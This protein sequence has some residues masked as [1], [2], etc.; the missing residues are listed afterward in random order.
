[1]HFAPIKQ[2]IG[3]IIWY[4]PCQCIISWKICQNILYT[5]GAC[6]GYSIH[7]FTS[8][9]ARLT[10]GNVKR[11]ERRHIAQLE[12]VRCTTCNGE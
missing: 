9:T 8:T 1:M 3:S 10:R 12:R 5:S 6:I 4:R 11:M 7:I 2:G